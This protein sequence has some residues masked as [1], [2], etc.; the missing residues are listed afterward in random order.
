[1]KNHSFSEID[2][3]GRLYPCVQM[4]ACLDN[5][6][7]VYLKFTV[8]VYDKIYSFIFLFFCKTSKNQISKQ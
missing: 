1:M 5:E 3:V 8:L 6:K 4:F 7:S 2:H